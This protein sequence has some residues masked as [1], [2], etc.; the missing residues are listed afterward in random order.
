MN[1]VEILLK[2][3]NV[4]HSGHFIE[5]NYVN[6]P[7]YDNMWGI[8]RILSR[9]GIQTIGVHFKEKEE[10]GLTFP[11]I[12]HRQG[13]FVVGTDLEGDKIKYHDGKKYIKEEIHLFNKK[14]TGKVLFITEKN[15]AKE[16]D[17][18]RNIVVDLY[19]RSVGY[20][21]VALVFGLGILALLCQQFLSAESVNM[22][23]DLT[24]FSFC[25]LLFQKQLHSKSTLA[26]R[27][28]SILQKG[29]CDSILESDDAKFFN[30]V[31]WTEI[32]LTYF[33][34]RIILGCLHED[35]IILL[36]L[37]GWL[38]MPFGVWSIWYQAY[39]V[40]KWCTLCSIT[41]V[42]VW[43]TG[44]YNIFVFQELNFSIK[45]VCL[46]AICIV[47]VFII[48]HT[49]SELHSIKGKYYSKNKE[50]LSFKSK[51]CIFKSAIQES[52]KI[53]VK[54]EDSSILFGNPL[55]PN[56]LSILSNPH[57][58]PCA[59]MHI[60]TMKLIS[61]NPNVNIQYIYT[62]FNEEIKHSSLFLIAVYQ[63]KPYA[64]AIKILEKW[65]LFGRLNAEKFIK[66]YEVD[67]HESKVLE[68]YAKHTEWKRKNNIQATPTLI[69]SGYELPSYYNIE[70][71]IYLDF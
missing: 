51:E 66:K 33:S 42:I 18:F 39:K 27:V 60:R 9:Y 15:N 46:F 35:G 26:D 67:I 56:T 49:L 29:G 24:G 53:E 20:F 61:E 19:Y 3:L 37:I 70:D 44:I 52:K 38:A 54:K 21:F 45:D 12:L 10:A 43:V 32:G 30:L 47:I 55:A 41:Q 23:F 59:D 71:F 36:Q 40:K 8:R 5:E 63:Q 1:V 13:S 69:F 64:E 25:I 48:I 65:Y 68:E 28:C 17:L 6:A 14:W 62:S 31:S 50:Y 57:C 11:C 58:N 34:S 16:P 2:E 4:R 7:D 22:F